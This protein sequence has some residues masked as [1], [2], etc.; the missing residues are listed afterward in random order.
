M[1]NILILTGKT[2]GGHNQVA[3]CLCKEFKENGY[4]PIKIDFLCEFN[5]LVKFIVIDL[6]NLTY[7]IFPNCYG[8]L[9]KVFNNK[10]ATDVFYKL[11]IVLLQKPI[12]EYI[13]YTKPKIILGVHPFV[14]GVFGR[15]K[16]K[17]IFPCPLIEIVTDLKPHQTY[18]SRFVDKYMCS[19]QYSKNI[20][21][22]KGVNSEKILTIGIPI[23]KEFLKYNN[24]KR[25]MKNFT[26][27]IMGGVEGLRYIKRALK[28]ILKTNKGTRIIVVCGKNKILKK[29]LE[30][31]YKNNRD[32]TVLGY[33]NKIQK[34]MR[35]SNILVTKAGGITVLEAIAQK[36]PI[37]IPYYIPGQE[38]ENT[39]YLVD[40]G[41]AYKTKNIRILGEIV[42]R[43]KN[44]PII[45]EEMIK[46]M[47]AC[48]V[49]G[50]NNS[51]INIIK[52]N[53]H[54]LLS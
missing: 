5:K 26:I 48:E 17:K 27:M 11:L 28:S 30:N 9:Y 8:F 18:V 42:S 45:I 50:L 52:Q 25:T 32:V 21:I 3:E 37:I 23:K 15:L 29:Q 16:E 38:M 36:I 10:L 33:S 40:I 35:I 12:V 44:N 6:Y 46:K 43:M 49:K 34:L 2:G 1:D 4:N 24:T 13:N 39:D 51:I 22:E 14:S 31:K 19:T 20:L 53:E 7:R 47:E 41:I 54:Q